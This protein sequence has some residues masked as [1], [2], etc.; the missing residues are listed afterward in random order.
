MAVDK[1][2]TRLGILALVGVVLFSLIGV[3]LWFLQTVRAEELQARV[4]FS[5]TRTVDLVPERGRIFDADGRILAD[6][7]PILT[8]AVDYQLLR[9]RSNREEIFRRLSG[10]IDVPIEEMEERYQSG[11]YSPLLPM[12]VKEDVDEPTAIALLERVEDFPGVTVLNEYR[13]VYPYAPLAAHT[14]GY[15]GAITRD[16]K[17]GYLEQGYNLNERVGQFGIERSM[18]QLLHGRWGRRVY[19]VDAAQR[20]VR[21]IEEV[22]PIPGYD[23]QLTVDLDL[24][25]YAEQALQTQLAERRGALAPNPEV[26][27]PDGTVER[28]DPFLP[29]EVPYKAPAGSVVVLNQNTGQVLALASYPTFDNR[30]FEAGL[31]SEKFAEIFPV[32]DDP[33]QSILVNR[34]IQGRYNLGSTFKPF[35]AYAAMHSALIDAGDRYTDEGTYRMY[36]VDQARCDA[37]LVR[38]VY[39]NAT[40]RGTGRPCVYGSVNV[41]D[42]LAVSSDTFFYKLGE[43]LL[44]ENGGQPVL[45]DQV[46]LFGFGADSG[47]DLPFEFDGTVPDKDLKREYAERGII[48]EDEGRGYYA[49]DNVQLAIGQGLL[50]ASPIQLA[51]AYATIGNGGFLY[52]PQI[53]KAVWEPGVPD[54]DVAGMADL[55]QGTV[56]ESFDQPDLIRQIEFPA[57]I[58]L[59]II[60]GLRRV[61]TPGAGVTSDFYHATTGENLFYNYPSDGI[62][63]AGK[64]GT[65]QGANNYPWNDSSAFA[66]F[67]VDENQPF[68]VAAYLEK[69]GYGSQAAAPVVKCAFMALSG[70]VAYDPVALADPLDITSNRAAE[71]MRLDDT[72]CF[73]GRFSLVGANE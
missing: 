71:P 7:E 73:E 32:T 33:D 59:P 41:T 69:S 45:Q 15:M 26:E 22:P 17:D 8:V 10:W 6:N 18:E 43:E 53:L 5:K 65:A 12:P 21:L 19:E 56:H 28:L 51:N 1:R 3:R 63:V 49:G 70:H 67:S 39:K 24:Q 14:V 25:Q 58:R 13:R 48:S 44:V 38:C 35:T 4:E 36:S 60:D 47:I 55:S 72:A 34:A 42:A 52:R 68:T 20:P 66:A 62:P 16:Q 40:C 30:W 54:S 31:S 37:G 2:A 57:E 9:T 50:S 23:I 64:T 11:L 46:K 29:P 61:V 27:K